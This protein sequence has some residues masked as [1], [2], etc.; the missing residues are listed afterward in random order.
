[1]GVQ[2]NCLLENPTYHGSYLDPK[3]C[4][5]PWGPYSF[6]LAW[7]FRF[8][9]CFWYTFGLRFWPRFF[10]Q[11]LLGESLQDFPMK[12]LLR[13]YFRYTNPAICQELFALTHMN[14]LV[15][16][17][18]TKIRSALFSM[19]Q[20]LNASMFTLLSFTFFYYLYHSSKSLSVQHLQFSCNGGDLK[21]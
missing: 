6:L 14:P 15:K 4:R 17:M 11:K 20:E 7:G 9:E 18:Q 5:S 13:L 10:D 16:E 12:S 2:R 21:D 3:K 8:G 1:M 19:N